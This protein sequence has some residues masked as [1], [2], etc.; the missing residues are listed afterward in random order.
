[1]KTLLLK[2]SGPM[3]LWG[4][5]SHFNTRH[6]DLYP[7][8]SAII[9]M[10]AASLGYRRD[11]NEKINDLNKKIQLGIRVDQRGILSKDYHIAR[12]FDS[13]GNFDTTY[14][15][16]RYYLQDAVFVVAINSEDEIIDMLENSV[17]NPYFQIYLGR[18]SFPVSADIILGVNDK[19]IIDNFNSLP[20]QA[21][22][23]YKKRNKNNEKLDIYGDIGCFN[24]EINKFRK[25]NVISFSQKNRE[26][27]YRC[28]VESSVRND[29]VT[30]HDV[31]KVI[32]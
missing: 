16:N 17:K 25:D 31:F 19:S 24:S 15:T 29:D 30:N 7:S 4:T 5:S 11:E 20:W 6:T 22:E 28:E 23:W 26:F 14:V 13:K 12:K 8:K 2:L 18:R 9:G 32:E 1:M 10:L 21:Q 27:V 3:Q